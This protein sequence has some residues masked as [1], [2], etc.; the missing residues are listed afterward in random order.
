MDLL[1]LRQQDDRPEVGAVRTSVEL[2]NEMLDSI[3]QEAFR[4]ST[5]TFLDPCFGNGTFLIEIIKRLVKNGH[6]KENIQK[7]VMGVELE[8]GFFNRTSRKL[9]Q[10]QPT[11]L[12]GDFLTKQF[13]MKFDYGIY[14]PP[15]TLGGGEN[16]KGSKSALPAFIR[17]TMAIADN[18]LVVCPA[19][20]A[21]SHAGSKKV[22]R[23][24]NEQMEEFGLQ[25]LI[26]IDQK[27][28]FPKVSFDNAAYIHL[29]KGAN[30]S[31]K[32]FHDLFGGFKR[33]DNTS[34]ERISTQRG[35][36]IGKKS[37]LLKEEGP[38]RII[39]SI[40]NDGRNIM[41]I[42]Y[43]EQP[44]SII[45]APWAV[46]V[47][48]Q[49][50]LGIKDAVVVDNTRGDLGVTA[51]VYALHCQSEEEANKLAQWVT[52]DSFN[53]LLK[54]ANNSH[55]VLKVFTLQLCPFHPIYNY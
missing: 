10:I 3:P 19:H 17:K 38:F 14:N 31:M 12:Q 44:T 9:S 30:R 6:T 40:S 54:I 7:R 16:G 27:Q 18:L 46:I 43:L 47:Q 42:K 37:P 20:F 26:K 41:E 21:L 4:S 55:R 5:T 11:L 35:A 1:K 50:G 48:E 15:F 52:T 49:S 22:W 33:P 28:M 34:T 8:R 23:E 29:R 45:K 39:T 25:D 2:V 53:S 32:D 24:L 36:S 51:N 13:D